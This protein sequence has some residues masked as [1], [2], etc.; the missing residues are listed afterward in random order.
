[1]TQNQTQRLE[2]RDGAFWRGSEKVP[3]KFGDLEQIQLLKEA[4]KR[5][6][7]KETPAT[8]TTEEVGY[9]AHVQFVCPN[10]SNKNRVTLGED[11]PYEYDPSASDLDG[12]QIECEKCDTC[13]DIVRGKKWNEL[14]LK[15]CE[16]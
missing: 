4:E 2:L 10:C 13:F 11:D 1:M 14:T 9:V 8:F 12:G 15:E 6:Q 3:P 16:D 5:T 7:S